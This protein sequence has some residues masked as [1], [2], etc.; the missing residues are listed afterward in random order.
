MNSSPILFDRPLLRFRRDRIAGMT[1]AFDFLFDEAAEMLADRLEDVRRT[2]P[3]ALILGGR[4]GTFARILDGRGGIQ[5]L[6]HTDLSPRMTQHA[7]DTH[8]LPGLT[9]FFLAADEE[10]LPFAPASFDLVI[11]P[12]NLHWVNDLPGTLA[13]IRAILKPDGLFLANLLG[14]ETL[15]ELRRAWMDAEIVV[16][17]GAGIHVSPFLD[18][19][20]GASL[21][22]RAGFTLPVA[23]SDML[24]VT[25]R[26]ALALMRDLRGMGETNTA[27]G[28]RKTMTRRETIM[29]M[30][31]QYEDSASEPDGRVRASFQVITLTGWAPDP[32]QPQPLR[33][34]SAAI[35][36][37][38]ILGIVSEAKDG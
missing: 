11:C 38:S 10:A 30:I 35:P 9:A 23:D 19:V 3:D 37:D 27:A 8:S 14:G 34:G 28:R 20:D 36:L 12:L 4:D 2:F 5:N 13:Q 16:E 18:L 32:S 26:D 15:H 31:R 17:N 7:R 21:L 22:Q 6:F 1:K 29:R 25:Y 33:P 24:T